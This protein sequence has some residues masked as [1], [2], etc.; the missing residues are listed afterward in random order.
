MTPDDD[1]RVAG[2]ILLQLSAAPR[3]PDILRSLGY[4]PEARPPANI[5]QSVERLMDEAA[6]YLEP[7]GAYSMYEPTVHTEHSLEIGGAT[8]TGNIGEFLQG[9]CRVAVFVVTVGNRISLEARARNDSGD[10]FG[11]LVLDTI[12]S[13]AAEL[14]AEALMAAM[15]S[16]LGAGESFTLRYSPGYCGMGLDQQRA[17]FQLVPAGEIGISLLPSLLMQPLKSISAIAGLGPRERVGIHL[18]PCERCPQIGCHMR[19]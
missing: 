6:A 4:P 15:G 19:R 16:E 11:G 12:G 3:L 2:R 18:S 7:R 17:L 10:A 13:W 1:A 5:V 14:T 8:I 9:A